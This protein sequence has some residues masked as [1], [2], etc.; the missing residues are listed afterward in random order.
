[1]SFM[2]KILDAF[3]IENVR[4]AENTTDVF[5]PDPQTEVLYHDKFNEGYRKSDNY[6]EITFNGE[7]LD[8]PEVKLCAV[9]L[10]SGNQNGSKIRRNDQY[11]LY[12]EGRYGLV[13]V[14]ALHRW[15]YEHGYLRAANLQEALS[16]YKVPELKTILESLGLKKT[17]NKSDL[18]DR[19]VSALGTEEKEKITNQCEHLFLTGKGYTFLEENGDYDMWHRKSYGVTFEEFNKHRLL[20]GKKR[21]FHDTIFQALNEKAF[22]YQCNQWF[23]RLGMIYFNLSE[24]LY[25]EGRYDLSLQNI[26]YRLYFSANL[27]WHT[28][29]FS[30]NHIKYDEI[31][32]IKEH[33]IACNDV[34]F[35]NDL[36]RI[37][38][39]KG[40]YNEQML[41]TI[42]DIPILPY[43]IFDKADMASV[44][45]D[46]LSDSYFDKNRYMNYICMKYENYIRKFL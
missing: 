33:I 32:R 18:I 16:L 22:T 11:S 41:D 5:S 29:Y 24:V 38:E 37:I 34:F 13:N 1:M 7:N 28:Y 10:L 44:I 31:D 14:S 8:I 36:K 40:F 39:L 23:S 26:L 45:Y 6:R 12:F 30:I 17:G 3:K 21:R 4:E 35:D 27:A 9:I 15:L 2:R 25:D 46:L 20:C 19:I 43:S 42:Y